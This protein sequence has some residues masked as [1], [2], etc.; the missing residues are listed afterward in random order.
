MT[1]VQFLLEIDNILELPAGTIRG[2]ERLN[3]LE[4]WDSTAL[5][6]FMALA[7]ENNGASL[8][9]PQIVGCSTIADLLRVAQVDA[10]S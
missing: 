10:D 6:M 7:D 5:L 1:R 3:D 4:K 8:T 2:H 9:P